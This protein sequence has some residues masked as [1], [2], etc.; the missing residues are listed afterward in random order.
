MFG[1][2]A[3]SLPDFSGNVIDEGRLLLLS[4][5]GSGVQGTVYLAVD[6]NPIEG[7]L[8]HYAVKCMPRARKSSDLFRL[9]QHQIR[10]QDTLSYNPSIVSFHRVVC[11]KRFIFVLLDL[12]EGGTLTTAIKDDLFLGQNDSIKSIFLQLLDTVV[13][14]HQ[15]SVYHRDLNPNNMLLSADKQTL[16][17]TDFGFASVAEWATNIGG[18]TSHKSPGETFLHVTLDIYADMQSRED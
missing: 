6:L 13:F 17:L 7:Q 14:L 10:L 3:N 12:C 5:L 9:H 16:F 2:T 18:T 15:E 1:G 11:E 8:R 4:V